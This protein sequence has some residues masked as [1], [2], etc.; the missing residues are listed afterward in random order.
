MRP[1]RAF[2]PPMSPTR[3]GNS[4]IERLPL[5]SGLPTARAASSDTG[6]QAVRP[7]ARTAAH[8][9]GCRPLLAPPAD[10]AKM[11][12]TETAAVFKAV[13]EHAVQADMGEPDQRHARHARLLKA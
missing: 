13:A 8:P 4:N 7:G 5:R 12:I 9:S 11:R 1:K 3:T 6:P 2:V 10:R